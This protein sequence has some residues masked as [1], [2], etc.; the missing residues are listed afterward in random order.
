VPESTLPDEEIIRR[1]RKLMI[2]INT[3]DCLSMSLSAWLALRDNDKNGV[4]HDLMDSCKRPATDKEAMTL[5]LTRGESTVYRTGSLWADLGGVPTPIATSANALVVT[6]RLSSGVL[7]DLKNGVPLGIALRKTGVR[8]HTQPPVFDLVPDGSSGKRLVM[9]LTSTLFVGGRPW[10]VT[11]EEI[12]QV[13]VT[14]REPGPAALTHTA[15]RL[16]HP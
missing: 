5:Q 11:D 4:I 12:D 3:M 7:T 10:A 15:L 1:M 14:H 8:R 6:S 16:N 2:L 13:V 9:R